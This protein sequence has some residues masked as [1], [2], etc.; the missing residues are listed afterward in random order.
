MDNKVCSCPDKKTIMNYFKKKLDIAKRKELDE[1]FSH[2]DKC[3]KGDYYGHYANSI[4]LSPKAARVLWENTD[5]ISVACA[6]SSRRTEA[7]Q[8]TSSSGKYL[9]HLI[10]ED[11]SDNA[12]LVIEILD[13][14]IKG[15]LSV[16][17][18]N[19]GL[20]QFIGDSIID[21]DYQVCFSVDINLK[22]KNLLID[23]YD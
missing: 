9:I 1:H 21:E 20:L 10:P 16:Q 7:S 13:H 15:R 11:N 3:I 5:T 2:C 6:D 8:L 19:N 14:N 22:L 12:L 18:L 17:Y 4:I 23:N